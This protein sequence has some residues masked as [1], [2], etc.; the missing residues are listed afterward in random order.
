MGK[1]RGN[2]S[3]VFLRLSLLAHARATTQE[4][5]QQC[6]EGSEVPAARAVPWP[7]CAASVCSRGQRWGLP[8]PGAAEA[9]A[10][11]RNPVSP[12]AAGVRGQGMQMAGASRQ[13]L[14]PSAVHHRIHPAPSAEAPRLQSFFQFPSFVLV[15]CG[16]PGS[17]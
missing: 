16:S 14:Q 4:E 5:A 7:A 3:Y 9:A 11:G 17:G 6:S 1:K 13:L 12:G 15:E 10:L 8:L 2:S